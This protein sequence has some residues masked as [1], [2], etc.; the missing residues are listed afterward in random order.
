MAV[1]RRVAATYMATSLAESQMNPGVAHAQALLAPA[2]VGFDLSNVFQMTACL[3]HDDL[4]T[5]PFVKV[6][7]S[8][9]EG[10]GAG[11]RL[12]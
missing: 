7:L 4:L 5:F 3:C 8:K 10:S 2:C 12:D 1:L 9:V 11:L 6:T